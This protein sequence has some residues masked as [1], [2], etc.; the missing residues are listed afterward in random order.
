MR[1]VVGPVGGLAF[2][3][4]LGAGCGGGSGTGTGSESGFVSC[5]ETESI[6]GS[7]TLK[8]CI[9]TTGN[10]AQAL[11]QS[12]TGSVGNVA[13]TFADGPCSHVNALGACRI[14]SGGIT[15]DGWYY[16]IGSPD[17]ADYAGQT[18]ADI[19]ALCAEA[20]ETYLPP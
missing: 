7:G 3:V 17:A 20:G 8:L 14:T 5:T 10:E 4:S 9:E 2:L 1:R 13:V 15:E 19:Q 6:P 18:P 12:C 16:N 11:R